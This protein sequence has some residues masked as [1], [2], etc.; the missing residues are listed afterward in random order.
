MATPQLPKDP[1]QSDDS[2][3][4]RISSASTEEQLDDKIKEIGLK[5]KEQLTEVRATE[6]GLGYINLRGFPIGPETLMLISPERAKELQVIC[7][8][9]SGKEIRVGAVEPDS[10]AVAQLVQELSED[11]GANAL[12][13]L[14]SPYSF[15][16]AYKL[17]EH[18]ALPRKQVAGVEISREALERFRGQLKTLQDLHERIK[19]VSTTD[20]LTMILAGAVQLE[21]SDIH[22]EAED[23]DIKLRYR[24]DGV[25]QTIAVL[26]KESWPKIVNRIKLLA[27][28][29]INID[30]LPQD[31]R[32]TIFT[33]SDKID[34]RV[35]TLPSAYGESVVMRLLMSATSG[36]RFEQLGLRGNTFRVLEREVTRPN[37]M[38]VTTGPTSSGKTTTL[39][40]ILNKLNTPERKIITLEDPIEYRLPGVNQS[41]IDHFKDYTFSRGLK[42]VLR[43]NPDVVMVGEI[44]DSETAEITIHAALT[45]HLVLSSLHTNNA[46]GAVPR[47]LAMGIKPFLV[48]PALNAVIAQRLVRRICEQCKEETELAPAVLE[49]V[50][51]VMGRLSPASGE[52]VD[53]QN[54]H[55]YRGAGC[56]ACHGL[57]LRGRIAI[58]EVFTMNPE[59]EKIILS[60]QV[61]EQVMRDIAIKNGMVLMVQDGLLK[62]LDGITTVEEVFR[63]AQ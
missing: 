12:L 16:W 49:N 38:I 44:R 4:L 55:F 52:S 59:I 63:V 54:L 8:F 48:S 17:Y 21:A 60:N 14:I 19:R 2:S 18:I 9:S 25:L 46:A 20:V 61:S 57:G 15:A 24:I 3:R 5:E 36:L 42:A 33:A 7:F 50:K 32:I 13:Y 31:G 56:S 58:F 11:H 62:A 1:A 26:S 39:Y 45:G 23:T 10:P 34:V 30:R 22:L 35:S 43:Q 51:E 47:F 40:A 27:G 53:L 29:K 41:Q 28:L 37:G 6:L